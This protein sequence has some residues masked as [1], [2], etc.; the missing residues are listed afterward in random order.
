MGRKKALGLYRVEYSGAKRRNKDGTGPLMPSSG[1][2][3]VVGY[4][5]EDALVRLRLSDTD[6]RFDGC[7]FHSVNKIGTIDA[8]LSSKILR[9]PD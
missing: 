7:V 2:I 1:C 4:S 9:T 3:N 8:G 6:S 5:L